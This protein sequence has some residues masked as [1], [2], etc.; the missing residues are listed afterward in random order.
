MSAARDQEDAD[1]GACNSEGRRRQ[2]Q[3]RTRPAKPPGRRLG[4]GNGR[5]VEVELEPANADRVADSLDPNATAVG[6]DDPVDAAGHQDDALAGEHLSRAGERAETRR[7]IQRGAAEPVLDRHRF[8]RVDAD[9]DSHRQ[10]RIFTRRIRKRA[11]KRDTGLQR[12]PRRG[13]HAERLVAAQL[14]DASTRGFDA[15]ANE[16]S[17]TCSRAARPRRRR[18][19]A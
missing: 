9:A 6:V 18:A 3:A 15:L 14:D 11:L 13:E 8:A 10:R 1:S 5:K 2:R 16:V 19:L 12:L 17:R 4:R 7:E